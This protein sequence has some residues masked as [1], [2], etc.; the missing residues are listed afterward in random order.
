MTAPGSVSKGG[1]EAFLL[2]IDETPLSFLAFLN[3]S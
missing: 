3:K 1:S 2:C